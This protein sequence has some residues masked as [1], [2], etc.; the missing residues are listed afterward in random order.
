MIPPARGEHGAARASDCARRKRGLVPTS[1]LVVALA[2]ACGPHDSLVGA[3]DRE[4]ESGAGGVGSGG[5]GRVNVSGGSGGVNLSGA[6]IAGNPVGSSAGEASGPPIGGT[7]GERTEDIG[8]ERCQKLPHVKSD[9]AVAC[10][11]GE[12]VFDQDVCED[13]FSHC[14]GDFSAV[15]CESSLADSAHCG[16]CHVVCPQPQVCRADFGYTCTSCDFPVETACNDDCADMRTDR[17]HC[18]ACDNA[19]EETETCSNS[20]CRPCPAYRANCQGQNT[21][22]DWLRSSANCGSCGRE[23]STATMSGACTAEGECQPL[24]CAA[25]R[26]DCDANPEDCESELSQAGSCGPEYIRTTALAQEYTWWALGQDGSS[27]ATASGTLHKFSKEGELLWSYTSP[28]GE[29]WKVELDAG[30][31][32]FVIGHWSLNFHDDTA[33]IGTFAAKLNA[34]GAP[35]WEREFEPVAGAGQAV[36]GPIAVDGSG[37]VLLAVRLQGDVDVDPTSGVDVQQF[38]G[39]WWLF[40]VDANGAL[41]AAREFAATGE[42]I[43]CH[44]TIDAL[45]RTAGRTLVAGDIFSDCELAGKVA[46]LG[47]HS[48]GN[49]GFIASM[50][51]GGSA[52]AVR[53]LIGADT[54][55]GYTNNDGASLVAYPDGSVVLVASLKPIGTFQ[56]ELYLDDLSQPLAA[57][58]SQQRFAA[59]FSAG[60]DLQWLKVADWISSPAATPGGGLLAMFQHELRLGVHPLPTL[61]REDGSARWTMPLNCYSPSAVGSAGDTFAVRWLGMR[62]SGCDVDLDPGPGV[63]T[64][65]QTSL[66]T[67]YRF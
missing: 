64:V 36:P 9:A 22:D 35:V 14:L 24:A 37:T 38:D 47:P 18:G 8:C 58:E 31:F 26:A 25:G 11:D 54:A 27:L 23:C 15:G 21:C 3:Q 17:A 41:S 33:D 55:S 61:W 4:A 50:S 28:R 65:A 56:P 57:V 67:T 7:H 2:L 53:W 10:L 52:D 6:P 12:C 46:P 13:G 48:N 16:Q 5:T 63:A 20:D 32:V 45:A 62:P 19:C 29:I 39:K 40:E 43:S 49:V 30:G 34:D 42:G 51:S 1:S 59:R 66:V 60:L 44:V